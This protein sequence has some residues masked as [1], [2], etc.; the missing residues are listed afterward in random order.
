MHGTFPSNMHLGHPSTQVETVKG[1]DSQISPTPPN[2]FQS[3]AIEKPAPMELPPAS[4]DLLL[5]TLL[6]KETASHN[7][8]RAQL[9]YLNLVLSHERNQIKY[10]NG[11]NQVFQAKVRE[12]EAKRATTERSLKNLLAQYQKL[13]DTTPLATAN[14]SS[15]SILLRLLF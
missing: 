9:S 10:L 13:F 11:I 8:T 3:S 15:K 1:G 6:N 14:V 12:A 5:R 4:Q 7:E 2:A